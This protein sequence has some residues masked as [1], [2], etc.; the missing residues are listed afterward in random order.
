[1]STSLLTDRVR[2]TAT[3][4]D[5]EIARLKLDEALSEMLAE[6]AREPRTEGQQRNGRAEL[7]RHHRSRTRFG[8]SRP[9]MAALLVAAVLTVAAS[10]PSVRAALG[11]L[12][13]TLAGYLDGDDPPG[14][15]LDS[16]DSVPAWLVS[17]GYTGQRVI[18]SSGPY[19]LYLAHK[20]GGD[21]S[22]GLDDSVGIGDSAAGWE[23]QFADN[24]VVILGPGMEHAPG[25]R[26]PLYGVTAGSVAKVEMRYE[27]GPPRTAPAHTGGF[28]LMLDRTRLPAHLVALDQSGEV[29][30]VV[31]AHRYAADDPRS[32]SRRAGPSHAEDRPRD[33]RIEVPQGA[34]YRG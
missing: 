3:V 22:F 18:A 10:V 14:R 33:R 4:S 13:D 21:Y 19:S 1:M 23:R 6:V 27:S 2:R 20:P 25:G 26:V 30:Q 29:L 5:D 9:A 28:V 24:A 34:V 17:E 8:M 7:A 32:E 15:P 12:G 11:D 16:S 31:P